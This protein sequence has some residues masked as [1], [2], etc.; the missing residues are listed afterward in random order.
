MLSLE[1]IQNYFSED[2]EGD[3]NVLMSYLKIAA[4]KMGR[5]AAKP[6]LQLYYVMAEGDLNSVDRI[7]VYA[8]LAYVLLPGDIIPARVFHL[9]GLTDD[10]LAVGYLYKKISNHIT[11]EID[12]KV[13]KKLDEWFGYQITKPTL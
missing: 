12:L 13:E 1:N 5:V 2:F 11:P 9:L 7:K 3:F 4:V 6:L 8:A 10:L